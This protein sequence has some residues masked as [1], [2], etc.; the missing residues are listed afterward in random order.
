MIM[1][2]ERFLGTFTRKI[3]ISVFGG[4][5]EHGILAQKRYTELYQMFK[6]PDVVY[7][8]KNKPPPLSE[9]CHSYE[10]Q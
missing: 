1:Q 10:R 4:I 9:V 3:S 2:E 5:Q 6:D 7:Y 8:V